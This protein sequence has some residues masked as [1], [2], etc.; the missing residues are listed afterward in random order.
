MFMPIEYAWLEPVLFFAA[1]VFVIGL[2]GNMIAF[3]NRFVNALVTALLVAIIGGALNYHFFGDTAPKTIALDQ[4]LA[5]LEPVLVA[6]AV[7]FVIDL[8]GNMLSFNSRIANALV[9]AIVFTIVFGTLSYV[10]YKDGS[11]PTMPTA[12]PSAT[13]APATETPAAPA[14]P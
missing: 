9:T 4:A 7:V 5:W 2:V 10:A 8:I 6:A 13:E 14:T 11:M 3:G 1:V 12:A